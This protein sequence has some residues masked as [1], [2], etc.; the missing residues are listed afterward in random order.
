MPTANDFLWGLAVPLV[1]AAGLRWLLAMISDRWLTRSKEDAA[2]QAEGSAAK[3]VFAWETCLPLALGAGLGYFIL[4][5]GPWVPGAHYEWIAVAVSIA[6]VVATLVGFFGDNSIVRF[7]LMPIAYAGTA[8][9]AGY[10]VMPTYPDLWPAYSVYLSC[11]CVG[12]LI[13]SVAVEAYP[14]NGSWPFAVVLIGT[15]LASA[16]IA[17]LSESMLFAQIT[18]L[19]FAVTLGMTLVG[20]VLRR[21]LLPGLG[22]PLMTYLA[23]MLLIAQ[24][25]SW[26]AVPFVSYWLPMIGPLLAVI[27]GLVI[28]PV[29]HPRWH[30]A[31]VILAAAIP[32]TVGVAMAVLT[33]LPE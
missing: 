15:S 19:T 4:E 3:R 26:S 10:L 7:G 13:L 28:T 2:N 12:V 11:W 25:N 30:A 29:K 33:T 32:A 1:V 16:G 9:G 8:V 23:A 27:A 24:T 14:H 22:L 17:L 20:L 18:G 21:P 6:V 31:A 5:L